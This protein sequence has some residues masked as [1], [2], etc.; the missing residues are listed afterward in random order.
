MIMIGLK[1]ISIGQTKSLHPHNPAIHFLSM[2]VWRTAEVLPLPAGK[3]KQYHL[4]HQR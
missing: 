3:D 1:A 2:S 4:G